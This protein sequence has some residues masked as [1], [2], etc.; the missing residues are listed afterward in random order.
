MQMIEK[1]WIWIVRVVGAVGGFLAGLLG[2][3]DGSLAAL[4]IAM[5]V[6]FATGLLVA[7][8]GKSGKTE[9]GGLSSGVSFLGL[10][11]KIVVLL[12]VGLAVSLD[13]ALDTPGVLRMAVVMFYVANEGLSIME[14]VALLGM[15]L[16]KALVSA[17]ETMR[18]KNDE[19]NK[20]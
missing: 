4:L 7:Y 11:K 15:K 3:W 14:N 20:A 2:G 5:A 1:V 13:A 8:H 19:E 9:T 10:T 17:L 18:D 12:L 16:P 6:D